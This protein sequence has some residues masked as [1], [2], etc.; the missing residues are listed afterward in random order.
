VA[1]PSDL[2]KQIAEKAM[3]GYAVKEGIGAKRAL[4][5]TAALALSLAAPELM[6]PLAAAE[7]SSWIRFRG[8]GQRTVEERHSLP[9]SAAGF[10][11]S[12]IALRRRLNSRRR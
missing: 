8:T 10:A 12:P 9:I 4:P 6:A 5:T 1:S 11:T 7:H 2:T 3:E